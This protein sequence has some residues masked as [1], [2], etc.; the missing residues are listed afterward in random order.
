MTEGDRTGDEAGVD[1]GVDAAGGALG[2]DVLRLTPYAYLEEAAFDRRARQYEPIGGMQVQITNTIRQVDALGLAQTVVTIGHPGL[3]RSYRFGARARL[4]SVRLPVPPL[5]TRNKGYVGLLLSWWAGALLWAVLLRIRGRHRR[6]ALMHVHCSELPWTYLAALTVAK[7]TGLPTVLTVHCSAIGTVHAENWAERVFFRFAA[8]AERRAL[9]RAER[10]LTLTDRLRDL[11]VQRGLVAA[12]RVD[13]VP[14][15][16]DAAELLLEPERV[17][18]FRARAG[19]GGRESVVLYCGR[20]A[21]EKGWQDFVRAAALLDRPGLRFV[22]CGDGNERHRLES[23]VREHRL[24][25]RF[26]ILGF[27]PRGDVV[28]AMHL[29]D[30]V[31]VP[32]VHEELGGTILE[33]MALYRPVVATAVGGIPEV[34]RDHD[35][36]CLVPPRDPAAIAAAVASLLADETL[37]A[38]VVERA[39]ERVLAGFESAQ[40]ADRLHAAYTR[41]ATAA[42]AP[43]AATAAGTSNRTGSAPPRAVREAAAPVGRRR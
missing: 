26:S 3:P 22:M 4:V 31:V 8:A 19:I 24:S 13:V 36:G 39:R 11:Y 28:A 21:A 17:E 40:V 25:E 37:R 9:A 12:D 16:V 42:T 32:S 41:A 1:A 43:A 20:I 23:M 5:R 6:Y 38:R 10:V 18:R 33:A 34:V 29:A 15:C 27:V 35:T 2:G 30:V 14:D 7:V